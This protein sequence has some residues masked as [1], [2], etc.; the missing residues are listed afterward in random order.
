[1]WCFAQGTPELSECA[2]DQGASVQGWGLFICVSGWKCWKMDTFY[3]TK[4]YIISSVQWA[5]QTKT[6]DKIYAEHKVFAGA[7]EW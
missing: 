4:Y 7:F 3:S 6:L 2:L 1:M 5:L